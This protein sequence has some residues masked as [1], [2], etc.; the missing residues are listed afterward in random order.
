M[1]FLVVGCSFFFSSLILDRGLIFL[2]FPQEVFK[3]VTYAPYFKEIRKNIEF[4]YAFQ[5]NQQGFRSHDISLA[6]PKGTKRIFVAGDSFVEG[7]GIEEGTRFVDL[8]EKRM[9]LSQNFLEWINGGLRGTGLDEY[10][11]GF[12]FKGLSYSPDGLIICVFANDV[13]DSPTNFTPF[14]LTP[15]FPRHSKK[16]KVLHALW[17]STYMLVSE[18]F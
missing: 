12:L 14:E 2:G 7:V 18:F 1:A 13:T 3:K 10:G 4:T 11:K 8:L 5:A 15:K 6:K 16:R 17:P 9:Q